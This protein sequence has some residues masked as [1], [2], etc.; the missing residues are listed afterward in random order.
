MQLKSLKEARKI[1][2][3]HW[4]ERPYGAFVASFFLPGPTKKNFTRVGLKGFGYEVGLY[5]F[6]NIYYSRKA[7]DQNFVY[8]KKFLAKRSVFYIT[9]QLEKT[10]RNNKKAIRAL[11]KNKKMKAREKMRRT[12]ELIRAYFPFIWLSIPLEEYCRELVAEKV[13]KYFKGDEKF[14]GE[15]S[16]PRKKN[17]YGKMLS[18]LQSGKSLAAVRKKYAW[19]KSRDGFSD[20]YSLKDLAEIKRNSPRAV[21]AKVKIPARFKKIFSEIQE[22]VFL[23]TDRTDK[24]Y[25]A[26]G[27]ARPIFMELAESIGV[28]FEELAHYD[29]ESIF[30]GE[31]RRYPEKF[32]YF[33]S[34]G[35]QIISNQPIVSFAENSSENIKGLSAFKGVVRGVVKIIRHPRELGKIKKGE[36]LVSPMTLPSF[37][38]AMQKASAFVTDEGGIT[39]HAAI[40]ARELKKPCVIGTKIATKVLRDGDLV[41]VDADK[42]IVKILK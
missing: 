1:E 30:A 7:N 16:A 6:P 25:E 26:L 36:V 29:L 28:S 38:S 39:C 15:A 19:L 33:Y 23:R 17:E 32:S 22:L 8:L 10:H 18:A 40:I 41:E 21:A 37:I 9:R 5:Q 20:F 35:S 14:I 11:V 2:W 4:L 34:H 27:L 31:P 3:V 24:F 13:E 12:L 42:G